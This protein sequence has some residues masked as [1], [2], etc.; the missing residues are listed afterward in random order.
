MQICSVHS[1]HRVV[2]SVTLFVFQLYL[3]HLIYFWNVS[4]ITWNTSSLIWNATSVS[5]VDVPVPGL[6]CLRSLQAHLKVKWEFK[7]FQI[8]RVTCPYQKF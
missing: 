1:C 6:V 8:S 2:S 4:S 5:T 3:E 7:I